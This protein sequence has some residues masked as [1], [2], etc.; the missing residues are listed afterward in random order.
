MQL[1]FRLSLADEVYDW[2]FLRE[3]IAVLSLR[4]PEQL[5]CGYYGLIILG[6]EVR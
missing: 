3:F 1:G 2:G 6:V 5:G 4:N